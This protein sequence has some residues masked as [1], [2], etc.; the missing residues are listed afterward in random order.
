MK[1]KYG[2]NPIEIFYD[3][4]LKGF[5]YYNID[6]DY[7]EIDNILKLILLNNGCKEDPNSNQ[8]QKI[9]DIIV[10]EYEVRFITGMVGNDATECYDF[11]IFNGKKVLVI[12]V[13]YFNF[14]TENEPEETDPYKLKIIIGNSI[15]YDAI[16]KIVEVFYLTTEPMPGGLLT[17]AMATIQRWNQAIIA[18]HIL[19]HFKPVDDI[20]V[21]DIPINEVNDILNKDIK[22][23]LYGIRNI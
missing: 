3:E 6:T 18:I 5:T 16:R 7:E 20:D 22:I 8:Y 19:N 9:S 11:L 14:L 2:F 21:C 17:T 10:D 1:G 23:Q 13:D 4:L 15:Y 12:F